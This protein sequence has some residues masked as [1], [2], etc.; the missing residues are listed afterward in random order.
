MHTGF[1]AGTIC[2]LLV[3]EGTP[4]AFVP[5]V[6]DCN[7]DAGLT[8][9]YLA[10]RRASNC[11]TALRQA[12]SNAIP[13]TSDH[14]GPARINLDVEAILLKKGTASRDLAASGLKS[15]TIE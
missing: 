13:K 2:R 5:T 1:F 15:L 12:K 14:P 6:L 7:F 9:F 11:L 10:T 8:N 4:D 3:W